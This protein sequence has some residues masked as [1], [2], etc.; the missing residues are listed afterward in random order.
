MRSVQLFVKQGVCAVC[1]V[2]NQACSV[3]YDPKVEAMSKSSHTQL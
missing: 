3:L 1:A 2:L